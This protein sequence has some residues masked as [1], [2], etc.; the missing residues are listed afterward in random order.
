MVS[1]LSGEDEHDDDDDHDLDDLYTALWRSG[2]PRAPHP[3]RNMMT[4]VRLAVV[5][6]LLN[7]IQTE[8][9]EVPLLKP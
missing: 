4:N 7:L 3:S 9:T 6:S 5:D 8:A 2:W 1:A